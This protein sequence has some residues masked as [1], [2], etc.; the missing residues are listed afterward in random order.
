M[1][2]ELLD[3][4]AC[5]GCRG[6]ISLSSV[7]RRHSRRVMEGT[8]ECRNCG[9]GYPVR[10]GIP[11]FVAGNVDDLEVRV[12]DLFG[13]EFS[14][15]AANDD[16][17]D[18]LAV[19]RG[20]FFSRT[21]LDPNVDDIGNGDPFDLLRL[22]R[23]GLHADGSALKGKVVLDAGCGGGRFTGIISETASRTV[24]LDLGNQVER[25]FEPYAEDP[26]VDIVQG[27]VLAPPFQAGVFDVVVSLGVL[28]HT[29]APPKGVERLA[30][31]LRPGGS[32]SLMVYPPEYWGGVIREPF[33]R[34][35]HFLLSRLAI[36]N[37][38]RV[39]RYILYPLGRLQQFLARRTWA[40]VVAAPL[41]LLPIPRHPSRS[42]ML[43]TIVDYFC[44]PIIT[45]HSPDEVRGWFSDA[46]LR[47]VRELPV[48]TT[49]TGK[50]PG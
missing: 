25:A 38:L 15:F 19:R 33:S 2:D 26:R 30:A 18:S 13:A 31:L 1:N 44:P 32:L 9:Q 7:V 43:A 6:G 23:V 11:R 5:P 40:K 27:S 12:A 34:L 29:P 36:D 28:H 22:E 41:F 50:Q 4:L 14:Q 8:L 24:G 48:R 46:G 39:C 10:G 3:L 35:V 21:G 17:F 49:V 16:D 20:I 42:V 45:T 47:E 37:A